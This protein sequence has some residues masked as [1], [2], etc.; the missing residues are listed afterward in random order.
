MSDEVR[1]MPVQ[2]R[3]RLPRDKACVPS[4]VA[5]KAYEVYTEVFGSQKALIT[6]ECRGG[7]GVSELI[8]FLY[9]SSFPRS[10]WKQRV[11]EAFKGMEHL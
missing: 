7:F 8:A 6:G 5:L 9:A 10:E 4:V 11:D 1:T 2:T 3:S